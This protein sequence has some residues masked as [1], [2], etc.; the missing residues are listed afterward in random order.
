[1]GGGT[2]FCDAKDGRAFSPLKMFE[3]KSFSSREQSSRLR[4][5]KS[6]SALAFGDSI[7]SLFLMGLSFLKQ[8]CH[9]DALKSL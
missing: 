3:I 4:K 1:M 5:K 6:I 7:L 8:Y 2:V 9:L